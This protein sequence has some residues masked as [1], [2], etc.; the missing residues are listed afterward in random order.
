MKRKLLT[1]ALV[2]FVLCSTWMPQSAYAQSQSDELNGLLERLATLST[3]L[4]AKGYTVVHIGVERLEKGEGYTFSRDLYTGN[5]YVIVGMGGV[6]VAD[7]DIKLYDGNNRL[8]DED[9]SQ[10]NLALV[11]VVPTRSGVFKIQPSI[12]SLQPGY[13]NDDEYFVMYLIAFKRT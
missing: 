12:Y 11:D 4:D 6:G 1:L 5:N 8:I 3:A 9:T 10:E 13:T 2:L 7:L